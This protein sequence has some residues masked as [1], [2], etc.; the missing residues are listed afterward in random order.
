MLK[1]LFHTCSTE[2]IQLFT[3]QVRTLGWS[4]SPVIQDA[5]L[6][7]SSMRKDGRREFGL[8]PEK[9]IKLYI[10]ESKQGVVRGK[11]RRGKAL[12]TYPEVFSCV[13]VIF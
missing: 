12:D 7:N 9:A 3:K 5:M 6:S 10:S 2:Q 13:H 1:A 8:E 11:Y 4:R